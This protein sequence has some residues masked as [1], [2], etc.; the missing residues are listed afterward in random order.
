MAS[1]AISRRRAHIG[2]GVGGAS[3][4]D[5][6]NFVYQNRNEFRS[7]AR[8]GIHLANR[9]GAR[10]VRAARAY[11]SRRSAASSAHSSGRFRGAA[12]PAHGNYSTG[13][14]RFV[15]RP[16]KRRRGGRKRGGKFR[17]SRRGSFTRTL[18]RMFCT[19]LN[20]KEH[21][22]IAYNA[23]GIGKQSWAMHT[24][25]NY[26][27]LSTLQT[28]KPS[29]FNQPQTD[30]ALAA[31][32]QAIRDQGLHSYYMNIDRLL[33]K[34][35]M[36]NRSNFSMKLKVYEVLCR[37]TMPNGTWPGGDSTSTLLSYFNTD[38]GGSS[39][40]GTGTALYQSLPGETALPYRGF[41]NNYEMPGFT[42]YQS[43]SV[44]SAWKVLKCTTYKLGPNDIC[45]YVVNHRKKRFSSRYLE[46]MS[47]RQVQNFTKGLIFNWIGQPADDTDHTHLTT[48]DNSL[49]LQ[50]DTDFQFHFP[51]AANPRFFNAIPNTTAVNGVGSV[52][53]GTGFNIVAPAEAVVQVPAVAAE[54]APDGPLT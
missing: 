36:Q 54:A 16:N 18:W 45:T 48:S 17:R 40:G 51:P 24:L 32:N 41:A 29:L 46:S 10:I 30:A 28:F 47:G 26:N 2:R 38:S 14:A 4:G 27:T 39:T 42:L 35:T 44:C 49:V 13:N 37:V 1:T 53:T 34:Y 19:P 6:A 21:G 15:T 12:T 25:G 8:R 33:W 3:L 31:G 20:Y 9:A 5:I 22:A 52:Y 23:S 7:A 43:S 11:M 50:W